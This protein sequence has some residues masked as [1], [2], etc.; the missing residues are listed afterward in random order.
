MVK[1]VCPVCNTESYSANSS[2]PWVCQQCG[3]GIPNEL[4]ESIEY[5]KEHNELIRKGYIN[6][7]LRGENRKNM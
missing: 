1:R 4:N 3:A 5:D 2:M 7:L 6:E